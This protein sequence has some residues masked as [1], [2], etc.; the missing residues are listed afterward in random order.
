MDDV[1]SGEQIKEAVRQAN[2][3]AASCCTPEPTESSC[4]C[5]CEP[6]PSEAEAEANGC[7]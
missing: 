3:A 6:S 2:G 7:C 1:T 5:T 4:C